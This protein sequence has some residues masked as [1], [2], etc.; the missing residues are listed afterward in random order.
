MERAVTFSIKRNTNSGFEFAAFICSTHPASINTIIHK[1]TKYLLGYYVIS[2]NIV[3]NQGFHITDA[4]KPT[5]FT[6]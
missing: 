2:F 4:A 5:E 1:F 6:D 3:C